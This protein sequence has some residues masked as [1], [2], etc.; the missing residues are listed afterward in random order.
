MVPTIPNEIA[1]NLSVHLTMIILKIGT[2]GLR[3]P[4]VVAVAS[5]VGHYSP[6]HCQSLVSPCQSLSD[7]IASQER[8]FVLVFISSTLTSFHIVTE[9]LTSVFTVIIAPK[10]LYFQ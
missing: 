8:N 9:F 6:C 10:L 5:I 3:G 4:P 1:L 2:G 7:P